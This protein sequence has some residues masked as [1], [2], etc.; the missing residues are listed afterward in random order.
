M[1]YTTAQRDAENKV[2]SLQEAIRRAQMERDIAARD[3]DRALADQ[4]RLADAIATYESDFASL[5]A[6][7]DDEA[8]L[9]EAKSEWESARTSREM[10]ELDAAATQDALDAVRAELSAAR[11]AAAN[12]RQEQSAAARELKSASDIL[13]RL[14]QGTD[15]AALLALD[16]PADL[17]PALARAA[18]EIATAAAT[19]DAAATRWSGNAHAF[20][21]ADWA[22]GVQMFSALIAA[23]DAL[24]PFLSS[25]GLVENADTGNA[26]AANLKPGQMLV[27]REGAIWRWDGLVAAAAQ[28]ESKEVQILSLRQQIKDVQATLESFGPQIESADGI[29]TKHAAAKEDL[30]VKLTDAQSRLKDLSATIS[31]AERT[32]RELEDATA[33]RVL[34][35]NLAEGRLNDTRAKADEA[36]ASVEAAQTGFDATQ[37]PEAEAERETAL[38]EGVS[39][40]ESAR[41]LRDAASGKLESARAAAAQIKQLQDNLSREQSRTQDQLDRTNTQVETLTARLADLQARRE[42]LRPQIIAD[43]AGEAQQAFLDQIAAD[44]DKVA[45]LGDAFAV[46]EQ[47]AKQLASDLRNVEQN[48]VELREKRAVIQAT[49]GALQ[50]EQTRISGDIEERFSVSPASLEGQVM[51]Q[52]PEGAP[53]V[54]KARAERDFLHRERDAMGPVNLRA[55]VEL[56]EIEANFGQMETEKGE[57]TEAIARLREGID[58]LNI[59]ARE[60]I[61]KTFA[62]VSAH[63]QDLFKRLFGGGEAQIRLI[64]SEDPLQAGLEIYAQP[65]GKTLQSLSLLSGGEQ[66]LTALALIFAMFLSNPAPVCV[67]DEVDA[68][69]DDA[70]VDRVCTMLEEMAAKCDTR[71]LVI[72]HH[73]MTMARMGRLYGVTMAER[74]ISQLVSVNLALQGDLLAQTHTQAA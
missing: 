40:L 14:S 69:L 64:D 54:S 62:D 10:L 72:T 24:V 7:N 44:E 56:D 48:S 8:K 55:Q 17:A 51:T 32:V 19:D 34:K 33:Q 37:N 30:S 70:N 46:A 36:A 26:L 4:K 57:L 5:N 29:V 49:L 31:R 67:L 74:G 6:P 25:V 59:E 23:P 28:S 68:P 1:T 11:D 38:T 20:A 13:D 58:K 9:A 22:D 43:E 3:L 61:T 42:T 52:W 60:R 15:N 53:S 41:A 16:V 65:P 63:F 18:G 2:L 50:A 12:L 47:N 39:A 35:R 45:A 66:T 71:F 27:T 73:R 21:S